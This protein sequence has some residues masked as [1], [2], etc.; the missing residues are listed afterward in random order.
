[1][2]S[3]YTRQVFFYHLHICFQLCDYSDVY[4]TVQVPDDPDCHRYFGSNLD[5]KKIFFGNE[6]ST[7]WSAI[8]SGTKL[9]DSHDTFLDDG[10]VLVKFSIYE[11]DTDKP[12]PESYFQ[13]AAGLQVEVTISLDR[14]TTR[15]PKTRFVP[16]LFLFSNQSM[17]DDDDFVQQSALFNG[18]LGQAK[19]VYV[20]LNERVKAGLVEPGTPPAFIHF[21][22]ASRTHVG[23]VHPATDVREVTLGPRIPIRHKG[24]A[25]K[26]S[27]SLVYAYYGD[28]FNQ[29]HKAKHTY[30][31]GVREQ[32]V[33]LG[34]RGDGGYVASNYSSWSFVLGLGSPPVAHSESHMGAALTYTGLFAGTL[35]AAVG[36]GVYYRRRRQNAQL[37]IQRFEPVILPFSA[38]QPPTAGLVEP[39]QMRKV[40]LP[41][42]VRGPGGTSTEPLL[43][44]QPP[45]Y[46][47][48]STEANA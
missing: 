21:S 33:N 30:H 32:F 27:R 42:N 17:E 41:F 22:P 18:P 12:S 16:V 47:S 35:A 38:A 2:V 11:T 44:A 13:V 1:M 20:I 40:R 28:R 46:D 6:D 24:T 34:T 31:V 10:S 9:N 8:F 19:T 4:D 29:I 26:F 23:S 48:I 36:L 15:L 43:S 37:H 25:H 14:L 39:F 5:W 3:Y 7:K 45:S